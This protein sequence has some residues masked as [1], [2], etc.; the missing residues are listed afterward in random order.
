MIEGDTGEDMVGAG[1]EEDQV[2]I[3]FSQAAFLEIGMLSR[4][5]I[6]TFKI[7]AS[8]KLFSISFLGQCGFAC[9]S[10]SEIG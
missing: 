8:L 9:R 7:Y 5:P 1:V 10:S 6:E 3:D 2:E 4:Q